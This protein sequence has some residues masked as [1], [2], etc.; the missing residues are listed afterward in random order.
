LQEAL[1]ARVGAVDGAALLGVEHIEPV[2]G[3]G[4]VF[5][6]V[7]G[8]AEGSREQGDGEVV[9]GVFDSAG[10]GARLCA[11]TEDIEVLRGDVT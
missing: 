4:K 10:Y 3:A 1:E 9:V 5:V 6:V 2:A 8:V 11:Y 7:C